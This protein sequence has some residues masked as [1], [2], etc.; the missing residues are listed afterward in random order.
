V[1]DCEFGDWWSVDRDGSE[2]GFGDRKRHRFGE[3]Y[4]F[5]KRC[6]FRFRD[7]RDTRGGC[8]RTGVCAN[9]FLDDAE[10]GGPGGGFVENRELGDGG[11]F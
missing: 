8:M 7:V 9:N 11:R 10:R 5:G 3:R 1:A 4:G 6:G 2:D